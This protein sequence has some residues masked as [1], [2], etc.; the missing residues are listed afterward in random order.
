[1]EELV[2]NLSRLLAEVIVPRL[3]VMQSN[4]SEQLAANARLQNSIDDL[5]IALENQFASLSSQLTA[6]RAELAATQAVL[7]AVQ[8]Q[9]GVQQPEHT[10]LI[11]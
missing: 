11:H 8:A 4:Q 7:Q 5:R 10:A 6:C 3:Q 1:M 2:R 9:K